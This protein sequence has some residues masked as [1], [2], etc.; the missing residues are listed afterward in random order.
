MSDFRRMIF[1]A[2]ALCAL[3]FATISCQSTSRGDTI[4]HRSKI[5]PSMTRALWID[6]WGPGIATAAQCDAAIAHAKEAGYNTLLIEVRKVGDAYYES[7]LE[8]RATDA[9]EFDALAYF[10][11]HA[12]RQSG[13]RVEAWI[14]ANRIWKGHAEP[15]ESKPR[16]VIHVHPEWLLRRRDL[17]KEASS[18]TPEP[19]LYLD[20]SQPGARAW[21]ADVAADIVRHY[22]VDAIHLDY[23]RYPGSEWGYG[24]ASLARFRR[25]TGATQDPAPDDAKF[26]QWRIDQVSRQLTEIR[27]AIRAVD[28][29]VD[30]TAATLTWG[31]IKGSDYAATRG[32]LEGLQDWPA[33]CRAGLLDVVYPM[34]YK[35][36]H[37]ERWAADY[38]NW[39][40]LFRRVRR[41]TRLVVGV[42]AYLNDIAGSEA[43]LRDAW[44]A[45]FDGIAV[46][47]YR[48]SNRGDADLARF[49]RALRRSAQ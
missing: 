44:R 43:Q 8:P 2:T 41:G 22:D 42:G 15:A 11:E 36:E 26:V 47:S 5:N 49:T 12:K 7:S 35:R 40:Q 29:A 23:I 10:I 25:D 6:S 28:P 48:S 37:D 32:Y 1:A 16:H 13:L 3:V 20:P 14:V 31:E 19:S 33:W 45:G 21:T 39:F 4:A 24:A 30:L 46:F 18:E 38:R 9:P 27:D 34:H 17:A